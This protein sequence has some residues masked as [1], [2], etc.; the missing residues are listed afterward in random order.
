ML[1]GT[2]GDV[3]GII[4]FRAMVEPWRNFLP[5][6]LCSLFLSLMATPMAYE[7]PG[8]G[9]NLS[10]SCD[11]S[12]RNFHFF[13]KR[14]MLQSFG[15]MARKCQNL[16]NISLKMGFLSL[17]MPSPESHLPNS[18]CS[19]LFFIHCPVTEPRKSI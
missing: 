4:H 5:S 7:V 11:P 8:Q 18:G 13:A 3:A 16:I 14:E 2:A 15:K 1:I 12:P 10:H 19:V 9:L 17:L 6:F